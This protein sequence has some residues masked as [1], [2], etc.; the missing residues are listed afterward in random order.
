MIRETLSAARD[1]GRLHEISMVLIR[2]GFGDLVRRIGMSHTLE[3]AGRVLN[4]SDVELLAD[5]EP[6]ERVCRAL[7]ELGPTFVKLGQMLGSRVDM[8]SPEWI[9]AFEKLQDQAKGV[10]WEELLPQLEEDLGT[11]PEAVFDNISTTPFA[12]ASIAQVHL[13]QLKTGEKIVLKI[14]R[15]GIQRQIEA[16]LRLLRRIAEI[17]E[18]STPELR[19]FR[20]TEIVRQFA[21]SLQR[22]L[23]LEGECRHAERIAT[24]LKDFPDIVIPEVYWRWCT[25]RLNV[26]SFIEGVRGSDLAAIEKAGL[27][28]KVIANTGAQAVM[29]M[30][31]IDGF[32]HA[33]PHPGNLICLP[34]NKLGLIDFGM[35]GRLA[36]TRRDELVLLLFA[37]IKKDSM[38]VIDILLDWVPDTTVDESALSLEMDAFLD[39]YHGR[40]LKQLHFAQLLTDLTSILR[41]HELTL[42]PDL[43]ILFKTLISLDGVGRKLD[44]DFN[45]VEIAS[46]L[47]TRLMRQKYFPAEILKRGIKETNDF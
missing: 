18:N 2:W 43:A 13:A 4:W 44:P 41:E 24:N 5:S 45:I 35:V 8:F 38:G 27:D 33:D 22:E 32:F 36:E 17:A 47:L 34:E 37:L 21:L 31:L 16:D 26:Q 3:K 42:P 23:D 28:K 7:Q 29:H 12:A 40:S 6:P 19:R 20:P 25:A 10:S 9:D 39:H 1:L 46:P 11:S 14:R 30:V 15:P